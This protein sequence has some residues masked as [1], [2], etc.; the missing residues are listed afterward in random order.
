VAEVNFLQSSSYRGIRELPS[1]QRRSTVSGGEVRFG[2]RFEP[3]SNR[4][5]SPRAAAAQTG[6]QQVEYLT[7]LSIL[8]VKFMFHSTGTG[9]YSRR[10]RM[11]YM[12][13]FPYS[14]TARYVG[15]LNCWVLV[16]YQPCAAQ[17]GPLNDDLL[18]SLPE[19]LGFENAQVRLLTMT[20]CPGV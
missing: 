3:E 4:T 12:N 18:T 6:H 7:A 19:V 10:I 5:L 1:V 14:K 16:I 20:S 9:H 17:D 2:N 15:G 8:V 11:M 13:L